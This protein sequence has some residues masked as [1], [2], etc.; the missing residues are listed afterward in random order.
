M[1]HPWDSNRHICIISETSLLIIPNIIPS[2]IEK[3]REN[4]YFGD[5]KNKIAE[6]NHE[7]QVAHNERFRC[8]LTII[9]Y[10]AQETLSFANYRIIAMQAVYI[11]LQPF[12]VCEQIFEN[13]VI[14]KTGFPALVSII[15]QGDKRVPL[16]TGSSEAGKNQCFSQQ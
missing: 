15:P 16:F 9:L 12:G 13:R 2:R 8:Y 4:C 7:I 1:G 10:P 14:S 11:V 6:S 3:L 5:M